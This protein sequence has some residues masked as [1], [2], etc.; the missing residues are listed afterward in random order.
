MSGRQKII[1]AAEENGWDVEA[2]HYNEGRPVGQ[3][4]VVSKGRK[5]I[6]VGIK[7]NGGVIEASGNYGPHGHGRHV[8]GPKKAEQLV[9]II[10][11]R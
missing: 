3:D 9:D 1:A 4:I 2:A 11:A 6:Y 8:I 5:Y 7:S 10:S